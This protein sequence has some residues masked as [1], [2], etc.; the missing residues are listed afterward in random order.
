M[1]HCRS[2][3][4]D[5]MEDLQKEKAEQMARQKAEIALSK[6]RACQQ[7]MYDLVDTVTEESVK[8]IATE[9]YRWASWI[10]FCLKFEIMFRFFFFFRLYRGTFFLLCGTC[11][12]VLCFSLSISRLV[13]KELKGQSE[14]RVTYIVTTEILE[15]VS[16]FQVFFFFSDDVIT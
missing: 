5:A 14:Q 1:F 11:P 3:A 2:V 9:E 13:E 7:L 6:D 10:E 16:F 12:V 8:D 15:E 4:E